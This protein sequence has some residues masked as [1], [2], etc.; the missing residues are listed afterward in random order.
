MEREREFVKCTI[1]QEWG[2]DDKHVCPPQ[3]EVWF[4]PE[5]H[6]RDTARRIVK[7]DP[8]ILAPGE[9]TVEDPAIIYG[10]TPEQA[11]IDAAKWFDAHCHWRAWA[12]NNET[13]LV[14]VRSLGSGTEPELFTVEGIMVPEYLAR[15]T[16]V[17]DAPV[18]A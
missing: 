7:V 2:W 17:V 16:E 18:E 6:Y 9:M 12:E 15:R 3:W 1:C 5:G 8:P 4:V 11:V 14:A 13:N 10:R